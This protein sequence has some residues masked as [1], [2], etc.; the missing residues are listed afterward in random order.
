MFEGYIF[1]NDKKHRNLFNHLPPQ[2][3]NDYEKKHSMYGGHFKN[4]VHITS[5]LNDKNT[6]MTMYSSSHYLAERFQRKT[7]IN[8]FSEK[9]WR[10]R[11]A[12]L[13]IYNL[14]SSFNFAILIIFLFNFF[15]K[16]CY[17]F[18]FFNFFFQ[19]CHSFSFLF[20][21]FFQFCHSF[22]FFI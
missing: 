20:Q 8:S 4:N 1:I 11:F 22:N 21:F 16:F 6:L 18:F 10:P 3:M 14:I 9:K 13:F 2:Y 12:I 17:S 7:L 5:S 15:F 19:L